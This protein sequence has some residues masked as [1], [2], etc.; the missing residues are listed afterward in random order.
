MHI[1]RHVLDRMRADEIGPAPTL[2]FSSDEEPGWRRLRRGTGFAYR[3][4]KGLRP[5]PADIQRI[6]A[7]A[8]PP[9]WTDVWICKDGCGHI[10]ATGRDEKGRKQYRYHA[11]WTQ[12][13]SATKFETLIAFA[14]VLP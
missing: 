1:A 6:R 13:R 9:A 11:D 5:D 8:I 3:D 14:K 12:H 7:L 2:A 4:D 10:Q